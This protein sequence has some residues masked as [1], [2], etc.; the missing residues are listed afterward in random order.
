MVTVN[1]VEKEKTKV[2]VT[3]DTEEKSEEDSDEVDPGVQEITEMIG[4]TNMWVATVWLVSV[5]FLL[6]AIDHIFQWKCV[7]IQDSEVDEQFKP[8]SL[9]VVDTHFRF[10]MWQEGVS[11][12]V[13]HY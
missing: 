2:K 11:L 1:V 12:H 7:K 9:V 3:E 5:M 13:I 4:E 10:K 6:N 8:G